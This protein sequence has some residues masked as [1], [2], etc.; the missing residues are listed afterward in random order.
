MVQ[1]A[2]SAS[3]CIVCILV[4]IHR[5]G[6]NT[7]CCGS[8]SSGGGGAAASAP[9]EAAGTTEGGTPPASV[10]LATSPSKAGWLPVGADARQSAS[11]PV[12]HHSC[13]SCH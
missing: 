10:P 12:T 5:V 13:L 3:I 1:P 9:V 4:C 7:R 8:G 2:L 11:S 6:E